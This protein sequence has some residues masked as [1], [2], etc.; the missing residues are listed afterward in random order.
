MNIDKTTLNDLS[1]FK[2]EHS[3]FSLVNRCTTQAGTFVLKNYIIQPPG[4]YEALVER[5]K[6]VKFWMLHLDKWSE[7]ISNGTLVMIEK[8]FEAADTA[9]HKPG[10]L[11]LF[12]DAIIQRLLNRNQYSFIRFSVSH[13][14]DFLKGCKDLVSLMEFNPPHDIIRELAT[15]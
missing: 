9:S 15:M 2:G 4:N 14:V 10:G 5:Q 7:A 8:Y 12:L 11:T 1:F 3:V 6:A 13:I